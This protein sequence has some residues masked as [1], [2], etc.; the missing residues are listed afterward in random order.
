M[1]EESH[2]DAMNDAIRAQRERAKVPKSIL[3]PE[4]RPA[5]ME[6]ESRAPVL[7]DTETE[8]ETVAKKGFWSRLLG[9]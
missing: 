5:P 4:D 9:R 7:D 1:T 8:T 3:P 2:R 6:H